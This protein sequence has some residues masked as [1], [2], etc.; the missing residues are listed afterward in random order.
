MTNDSRVHYAK[1]IIHTIY[2]NKCISLQSTVLLKEL[3]QLY[4]FSLTP[5]SKYN[6]QATNILLYISISVLQ[7]ARPKTD[8]PASASPTGPRP[9]AITKRSVPSPELAWPCILMYAT[10]PPKIPIWFERL[11]L[12]AYDLAHHAVYNNSDVLKM[13]Y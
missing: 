13:L 8:S 9:T 1:Y 12:R 6:F 7:Y 3:Y 10:P 4:Y 2:K 11:T 5:S